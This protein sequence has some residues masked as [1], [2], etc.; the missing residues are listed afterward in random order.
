[1]K[2]R[3]VPPLKDTW[4]KDVRR[5]FGWLLL[6]LDWWLVSLNFLLVWS[7][8][9]FAG[10]ASS[11]YLPKHL[12]HLPRISWKSAHLK[13]QST[14]CFSNSL[15]DFKFYMSFLYL[16]FREAKSES[17][18]SI[19]VCIVTISRVLLQLVGVTNITSVPLLAHLADPREVVQS[20]SV[21]VKIFS[22]IWA[23]FSDV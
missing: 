7:L 5:C 1:M 13:M 14:E 20:L 6:D 9:A 3:K 17:S 11:S 4:R 21:R 8:S 18:R 2:K 19:C 15:L 12:P 16:S 10:P 23:V 22:V